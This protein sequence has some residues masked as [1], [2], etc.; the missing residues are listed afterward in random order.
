M[1]EEGVVRWK[2]CTV[3]S[4]DDEELTSIRVWSGVG[5]C[6]RPDLVRACRGKFICKLVTRPTRTSCGRVTT[7]DHEVD[8]RTM[9]VRVVEVL[10]ARENHEIIDSERSCCLVEHDREFAFV[11]RDDGGIRHSVFDARGR[12]LFELSNA[13]C[14]S[15]LCWARSLTSDGFA[16][17][18]R[19]GR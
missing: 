11:R 10:V 5:H 16:G 7:L 9:T 1:T 13:V 2:A 19:C 6:N 8:D 3:A 15:V 18:C 14:A 4:S 12:R 17:H